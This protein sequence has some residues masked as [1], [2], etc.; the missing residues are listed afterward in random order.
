MKVALQEPMSEIVSSS[1][2]V[3]RRQIGGRRS[4]RPDRGEMAWTHFLDG[5]VS[6]GGGGRVVSGETTIGFMVTDVESGRSIFA[7]DA[8]GAKIRKHAEVLD[9]G[10]TEDGINGHIVAETERDT[11]GATIVIDV[12][13]F[14]PDDG[15]KLPM[16]RFIVIVGMADGAAKLD[17]FERVRIVECLEAGD[18]IRVLAHDPKVIWQITGAEGGTRIE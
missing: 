8:S 4:G 7:S 1:D 5:Q 12:W 11:D 9:N 13:S 18:N 10:H 6:E 17:G 15:G 16:Q 3:G 14:I 2:R